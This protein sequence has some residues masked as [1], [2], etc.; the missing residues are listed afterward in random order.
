MVPIKSVSSERSINVMSTTSGI[1][2]AVSASVCMDAKGSSAEILSCAVIIS[3]SGCCWRSAGDVGVDVDAD[4]AGR[5]VTTQPCRSRAAMAASRLFICVVR[6]C[7]EISGTFG[8][9]KW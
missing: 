7:R 3:M 8:K 6:L 1:N 5:D 2:G 4:A 9:I